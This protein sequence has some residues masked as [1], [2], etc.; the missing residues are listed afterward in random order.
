MKLCRDTRI[1]ENNLYALKIMDK[2]VLKKK[3]QG[4]NGPVQLRMHHLMPEPCA[5]ALPQT[6]CHA[7]CAQLRAKL[8]CRHHHHARTS[9]R[10]VPQGMESAKE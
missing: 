10:G 5:A 8:I 9:A 1:T 7:Y 6:P 4:E 2:M 3:R